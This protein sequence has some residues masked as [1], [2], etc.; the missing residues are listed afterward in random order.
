MVSG[1]TIWSKTDSLQPSAALDDG[2]VLYSLAG[3]SAA[4]LGPDGS[5]QAPNPSN[6]LQYDGGGFSFAPLTIYGDTQIG[7]TLADSFEAVEAVPTYLDVGAAYPSQDGGPMRLAAPLVCAPPLID[8]AGPFSPARDFLFAFDDEMPSLVPQSVFAP[9][10]KDLFL[11]AFNEWTFGGDRGYPTKIAR[12]Q[13]GDTTAPN[14][15]LRYGNL[16]ATF[17]D[18]SSGATEYPVDM[19]HPGIN[20]VTGQLLGHTQRSN[21][22]R[23]S[24]TPD[25]MF[26][27]TIDLKETVDAGDNTG[28]LH[29]TMI[30]EFGHMIGLGHSAEGCSYKASIMSHALRGQ[31]HVNEP[32]LVDKVQ[33]RKLLGIPQ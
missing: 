28:H 13:A 21:V 3:V 11:P 23:T 15:V 18:P 29:F 17:G 9:D 6:F 30:H 4:I 31:P 27:L 24:P 20:G 26:G 32:T 12:R 5:V 19:Y 1:A 25:D 33:L 22:N 7:Q 10:Q 14:L 2:S 16:A 8:F